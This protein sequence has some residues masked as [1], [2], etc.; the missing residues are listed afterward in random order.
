MKKPEN[1]VFYDIWF[2]QASIL[3][4]EFIKN[5]AKVD[6]IF[7]ENVLMTPHYIF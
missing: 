7:G 1:I 3:A 4:K 5:F 2:S 6:K